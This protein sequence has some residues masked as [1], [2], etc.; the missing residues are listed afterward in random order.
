MAC[1]DLP[2]N[3]TLL[4]YFNIRLTKQNEEEVPGLPEV[5]MKNVCSALAVHQICYGKGIF[6]CE[7]YKV[8]LFQLSIVRLIDHIENYDLKLNSLSYLVVPPRLLE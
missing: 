7:T 3:I 6:S 8:K 1:L 4:N 5:L 2:K